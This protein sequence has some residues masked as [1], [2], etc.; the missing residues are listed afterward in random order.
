MKQFEIEKK[1]FI[2][3]KDLSIEKIEG[4]NFLSLSYNIHY[5]E[6]LINYFNEEYEWHEMFTIDDVWD[7]NSKGD[8]LFILFYGNESIGYIW[9]SKINEKIC[10][11][12]NL[13]VTKVTDRPNDSAYWFYNKSSEIMLKKYDKIICEAEDWNTAAH[14][15]F[16][17]TGFKLI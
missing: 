2:K 10:K 7:R 3:L 8:E 17:K 11:A 1:D 9:Y 6:K 14:N 4:Q 12:Y 16:F 5:I 15:V 13:Y